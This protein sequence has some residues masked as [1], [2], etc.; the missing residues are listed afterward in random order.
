MLLLFYLLLILEFS[1]R[2]MFCTSIKDNS[3][4]L[5][6]YNGPLNTEYTCGIRT[7]SSVAYEPSSL[8]WELSYLRC[9]FL[10]ISALLLFSLF[11]RLFF[12]RGCFLLLNFIL[13][14]DVL[15]CPVHRLQECLGI[16]FH[17]N[18]VFLMIFKRIKE[19]VLRKDIR[20][21]KKYHK[22]T[23]QKTKKKQLAA[24]KYK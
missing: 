9:A 15:W 24:S 20:G 8:V 11:L 17:C 13:W 16:C 2:C 5:E 18:P 7:V 3:L 1:I 14:I 10:G 23:F 6:A 19:P 21:Y 4:Y 22:F 12:K